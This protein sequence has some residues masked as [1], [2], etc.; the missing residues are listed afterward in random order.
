M[1]PIIDP[2]GRDGERLLGRPASVGVMP[3]IPIWFL[4]IEK[5]GLFWDSSVLVLAPVGVSYERAALEPSVDPQ[6]LLLVV[7]VARKE[8]GLAGGGL[9]LA[10]GPNLDLASD[11]PP[12]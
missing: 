6:S 2:A 12:P 1:D 7:H 9:I 3:R 8:P 10:G 4:F 11:S 5:L